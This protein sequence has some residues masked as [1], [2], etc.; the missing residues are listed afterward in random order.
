M[1][2]GALEAAAR[3]RLDPAAYAYFAGGAGERV[4]LEDARPAWSRVRLRP[5][6]LRDVSEVTTATT[7]LG[8]PVSAP[9]LAAPVALLSLAHQTAE[10]GWAAGIASAGSLAVLS[11]RSTTPVASV[12]AAA[13]GAPWWFQVY[14][15][16]D[17]GLTAELVGRAA[18]AG[19]RALVLT[20]DTPVLSRRERVTL[21]AER[22]MPDLPGAASDARRQDP[23]TTFADVEWLREVS[24]GLPV[25]VKGVLRGD[26]A[27]ACAAAGA[28]GVVVSNHGGRQ[29][30]GAI[31]TAE[32]LPEVSSAV[33]GGAEVYVDG[34]IRSGIDVLRAIALG[35]RAVLV[36]RPLVWALA[37]GGAD[38]GGESLESLQGEV[39]E[40]LA[41]A[42]ARSPAEV[43]GD[44]VA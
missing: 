42:G 12:A 4:T 7:V 26:D 11:S 1:D 39:A 41:L 20:G 18:A 35:A 36:G 21:P 14:V 16:R 29:L 2:P 34:G 32:A 23:A 27:R 25:I 31:S 22:L 44:L 19:A 5:R 40:A 17:R 28:A 9:V 3:E 13:P 6:V 24:G 10:A 43:G 30:D 15:M 8:T 37:C 38:G 33:G